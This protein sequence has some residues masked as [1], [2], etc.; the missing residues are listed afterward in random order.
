[1]IDTHKVKSFTENFI[2]EYYSWKHNQTTLDKRKEY[3]KTYL[4]EEL[5]VLNSDV[6]RIDIPTNSKVEAIQF[7]NIQQV[8]D[9]NFEVLFSVKQLIS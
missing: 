8:D 7:W 1:M 3:L 4:T 5:Q 6:V 9:T 2:Q